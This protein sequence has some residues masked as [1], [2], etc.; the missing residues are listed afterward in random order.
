MLILTNSKFIENRVYEEDIKEIAP[1]KSTFKKDDQSNSEQVI[2]EK[3]KNSITCGISCLTER[4]NISPGDIEVFDRND[5]LST[6]YVYKNRFASKPLPYLIGSDDFTKDTFVGLKVE[7]DSPV[8]VLNY[9]NDHGNKDM[10]G[11]Q[12]DTTNQGD[13]ES[14]AS[15]GSSDSFHFGANQAKQNDSRTNGIFASQEQPNESLFNPIRNISNYGSDFDDD[16][17]FTEKVGPSHHSNVDPDSNSL[18][19]DTSSKRVTPNSQALVNEII[20]AIPAFKK[21]A[22]FFDS[23]SNEDSDDDLFAKR[24]Q[25]VATS[26]IKT[27]M[28]FD[29]KSDT[30]SSNND[31]SSSANNKIEK[32]LNQ[33]SPERTIA[34]KTVTS[35]LDSI[36]SSDDEEDVDIFNVK[37]SKP[38]IG[39][40]KQQQPAKVSAFSSSDDDDDLF[41]HLKKTNKSKLVP[42]L[43]AT[44]TQASLVATEVAPKVQ[45][46]KPSLV[47]PASVKPI[48]VSKVPFMPNVISELSAA[49]KGK[50]VENDSSDTSEDEADKKIETKTPPIFSNDE[51]PQAQFNNV[52][53]PV[54]VVPSVR[55][56]SNSLPVNVPKVDDPNDSFNDMLKHKAQLNSRRNRKRPTTRLSRPNDTQLFAN[57]DNDDLDFGATKV[58][59]IPAKF[60]QVPEIQTIVENI[61]QPTPSVN[62]E[63]QNSELR[64]VRSSSED[65]ESDPFAANSATKKVTNLANVV[66]STQPSPVTSNQAP[67]GVTQTAKTSFFDSSDESDGDIFTK[68]ISKPIAKPLATTAKENKSVPI[69]FFND[70]D[71]DDDFLKIPKA[72]AINKSAESSKIV[73]KHENKPVNVKKSMF[74]DDSDDDGK[75]LQIL[76]II[77]IMY[78][79]NL[80]IFLDL[81]K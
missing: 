21:N 62:V 53:K 45:I 72:N 13:L 6:L 50:K 40:A 3:L 63:R 23:I 75:L 14:M 79:S 19:D 41:S 44:S 77:I 20:S 26:S 8:I 58:D 59:H 61:N 36:F 47:E 24:P 57:D 42:S 15:D 17:I 28:D 12:A 31:T 9:T 2:I 55:V 56:E 76:I 48:S 69:S 34:N 18:T 33:S 67:I 52:E 78:H 70:S 68:S 29:V 38:K 27:S 1:T 25:V 66:V 35:R 4:Y 64:L 22:D 80:F 10:G 65:S 7:S 43:T 32:K 5:L 46:E 30:S 71:D 16:D 51:Q 54:F 60:D 39:S 11:F 49:L 37:I 74:D 81:F 73:V